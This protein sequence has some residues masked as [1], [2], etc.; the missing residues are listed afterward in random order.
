[1][2]EAAAQNPLLSSSRL[3]DTSP[4]I[5]LHPLVLLT[6]S[7]YVTR[8]TVRQ[9]QGPIVGAILGQQNGREITMEVAFP[10][11]MST[12]ENGDAVLDDVWFRAR[13]DHCTCLHETLRDMEPN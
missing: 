8:Y 4:H 6:I 5:Q 12:S 10:A 1:M 13:L 2:A 11:K 3:S 9:L 7:D